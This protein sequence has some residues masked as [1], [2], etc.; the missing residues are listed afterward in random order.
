MWSGYPTIYSRLLIT[1]KKLTIMKKNIL[2]ATAL[3]ITT[4]AG[5]TDDSFVGDQKLVEAN[6]NGA[7]SFNLTTPAIT[8]GDKT[9]SYAADDLGGQ[10]IVYGEKNE[11]SYNAPSDGNY[12]FPNY[13]VNWVSS[14]AYT[15]TSNTKNWEYVGYTHTENYQNNIKTKDG[16][17]AAVNALDAAQTIKYWDYSA[18][19][20][21]FTAVSAADHLTEGKTDIEKGFIT[22]QKNTSSNATSGQYGK[23]YTIGVTADADLSTLFLSDRT[24][25]NPSAN[26]NRDAE[27]SYGGNVTLRFR[28][29]LSHVRVGI[30]ETINGYYINH[31]KFYQFNANDGKL[32]IEAKTTGGSPES[33]FG[34]KCKNIKGSGYAGTLTVTYGL[35]GSAIENQPIVTATGTPN[36]NLLLGTNINTS[37]TSSPY[38]KTTAAEPSWDTEDGAYTAVMPQINNSDN[39]QLKCD[40][41]LYNDKTGETIDVIGA[42]AEV[43]YKYLQWKPNYKY[44]YLFKISDNTNGSTGEGVVGLYP[45]TFDA[46]ETIAAD[47]QA[48]YITTVSEPTITTFGAIYNTTDSKYTAYQTGKNEYQAQTGNNRLDIFATFVEGSTVATPELG[49]NVN[50]Y[51]VTTPDATTYP[52]TEA[53]VAEALANPAS[54]INSV[55]TCTINYTKVTDAATLTDGMNYYKT[56][57]THAPGTT[58]YVPTLAVAGTDY[59]VNATPANSTITEG[60]DIYTC[61]VNSVAEVTNATALAVGTTYYKKDVNAKEPGA[62]GY[63]PTIAIAGTDYQVAPKITATNINGAA[64]PNFSEIPAIVTSVPAED[65]TTKTIDALKLTGVVATTATTAYAIE[66]IKSPAAFTTDGGKTYTFANEAAFTAAGTLYTTETCDVELTWSAYQAAQNVSYYKKIVNMPGTKVYKVIRVN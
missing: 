37:V 49:T 65:G 41:T 46:V 17:S 62:T 39:L 5:C 47:G 9:G 58:G 3:A 6:G 21:T 12:V 28:N 53:S 8:R 16:E 59:T 25:I 42:T 14:S 36:N 64:S 15:T 43:P 55:Y 19:S 7:I 34:A 22:I 13:Q 1:N 4:L 29:V 31:I 20:Y 24:V 56:D 51:K 18:S 33:C 11:T 63:I 35:S 52:I 27:N 54:I 60:V 48:E 57:G 66:Y 32:S 50:V 2:L 10:F 26:T 44:T 23:G 40:Y 30:Y 38:M 61:E 45:I